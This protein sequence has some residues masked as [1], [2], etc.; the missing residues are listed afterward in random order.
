[1]KLSTEQACSGTASGRDSRDADL[2]D[3]VR[4]RSLLRSA[5]D[6]SS[7]SS[8]HTSLSCAAST[9]TLK[10]LRDLMLACASNASVSKPANAGELDLHALAFQLLR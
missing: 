1:M 6:G 7:G 10:L 2:H 9:S 4:R 3:L 5:M 8:Q